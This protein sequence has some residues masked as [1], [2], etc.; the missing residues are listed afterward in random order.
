ME[1]RRSYGRSHGTC[2]ETGDRRPRL[3]L[4]KS[5]YRKDLLD[6]ICTSPVVGFPAEGRRPV[7]LMPS[8]WPAPLHEHVL[9]GGEG[10]GGGTACGDVLQSHSI[11]SHRGCQLVLRSS[12]RPRHAVLAPRNRPLCVDN[13]I[14][15]DLPLNDLRKAD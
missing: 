12:V 2:E 10:G 5:A 1:T 6:D 4:C 14:V 7:T 3:G 15:E 11:M 8:S 13:V 9:P